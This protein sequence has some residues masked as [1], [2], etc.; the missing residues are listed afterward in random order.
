[1]HVHWHFFASLSLGRHFPHSSFC[2]TS[3]PLLCV[4]KHGHNVRGN[5][6]RKSGRRKTD[7]KRGKETGKESVYGDQCSQQRHVE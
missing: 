4:F 7:G 2:L 6:V 1:M 5:K 3:Q